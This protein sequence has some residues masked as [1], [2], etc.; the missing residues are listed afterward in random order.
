[1]SFEVERIYKNYLYS[2][3]RRLFREESIMKFTKILMLLL[4]PL[5]FGM[6]SANFQCT[7]AQTASHVRTYDG[8]MLHYKVFGKGA[9]VLLLSGGP[10][11]NGDY[12]LP[13]ATELSKTHQAIL[14]HQR[15]TDK[16]R[17]YVIDAS[18]MTLKM[19]VSD[20]ETL[21]AH[22][23]LEKLILIGHSW[24]GGL[25][26]AY[27]A[28]HPARIQALILVS[29][30]GVNMGSLKDFGSNI[31]SR[32]TPTDLEA[33]AFWS[34]PA[35][36]KANPERAGYEYMRAILP[37]YVF[38]RRNALLMIEN[39]TPESFNPFV[40]ELMLMDLARNYN[41]QAAMS[42]FKQPV[43]IVQGRQDPIGEPTANQTKQTLAQAGLE[44]IEKCGHFPWVEQHEKFFSII[45]DFLGNLK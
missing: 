8:A 29:S 3:V 20:I 2:K 11:L 12:L 14:L 37:G 7:A 40:A 44:F 41:V 21:R 31:R 22:L 1:M 34:E 17:N 9:P 16:S 5:C 25:A 19:A 43:L 26:M 23:K 13:V 15:G 38:E 39:L 24:G 36:E 33:A 6:F 30:V 18:T 10:G 45:R 42:G 4:C 32:L 28:Q 27:A 35:R